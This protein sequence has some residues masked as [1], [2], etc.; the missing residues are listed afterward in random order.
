MMQLRECCSATPKGPVRWGACGT[1]SLHAVLPAGRP[2]AALLGALMRHPAATW[3][4]A[5][6]QPR[7]DE[8]PALLAVLLPPQPRAAPDDGAP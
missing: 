4:A 5:L 6:L 1:T 8:V 2:D 3:A 7:A